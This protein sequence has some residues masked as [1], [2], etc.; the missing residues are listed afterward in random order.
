MGL[1]AQVVGWLNH[2]IQNGHGFPARL[3]EHGT[4][5]RREAIPSEN[6]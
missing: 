2:R 6:S 3:R 4:Q 1:D 5:M